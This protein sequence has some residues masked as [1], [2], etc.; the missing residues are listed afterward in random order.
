MAT[1]VASLDGTRE[2]HIPG[3]GV[4]TAVQPCIEPKMK[5]TLDLITPDLQY[6]ALSEAQRRYLREEIQ[7]RPSIRTEIDRRLRSQV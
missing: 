4:S 3:R 6:S 7:T 2:L 5:R 1:D